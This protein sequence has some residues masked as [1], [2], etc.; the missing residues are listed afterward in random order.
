MKMCAVSWCL[1]PAPCPAHKHAVLPIDRCSNCHGTAT[2]FVAGA[3]VPCDVCRGSGRKRRPPKHT[4]EKVA[5]DDR[6]LMQ[7]MRPK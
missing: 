3:A 1:S 2:H 7:K 6:D 5:V 4:R